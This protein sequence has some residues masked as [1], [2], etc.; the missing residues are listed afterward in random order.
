MLAALAVWLGETRE[1]L[2]HG[3]VPRTSLTGD[4]VDLIADAVAT[5]AIELLPTRLRAEQQAVWDEAIRGLAADAQNIIETIDGIAG[6]ASRILVTGGGA[7]S[8]SL[9]HAKR[10]LAMVPVVVTDRPN[11]S[12]MGAALIAEGMSAA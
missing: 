4:D 1:R 8:R 9:V 11:T 5:N 12:V 3:P 2:E 7:R 10:A 6:P